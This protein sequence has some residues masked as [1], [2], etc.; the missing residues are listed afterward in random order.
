MSIFNLLQLIISKHDFFS[1]LGFIG[2]KKPHSAKRDQ[3]DGAGNAW[4]DAR[5]VAQR[6]PHPGQL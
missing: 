5:H 4:D 6:V 2:G 3:R 1:V